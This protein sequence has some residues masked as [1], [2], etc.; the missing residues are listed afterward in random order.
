LECLSGVGFGKTFIEAASMFLRHRN[1][2]RS[3]LLIG[4]M[5]RETT[6]LNPI[7]GEAGPLKDGDELIL[8]SQVLLDPSQPLP[9]EPPL[10]PGP[11]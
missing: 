11:S 5:R 2:K 7:G 9:T 1:D 8:L 6:M 3:C 4:V 10:E